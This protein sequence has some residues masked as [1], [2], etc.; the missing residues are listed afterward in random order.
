MRTY[1][2]YTKNFHG[3]IDEFGKFVGIDETDWMPYAFV[4]GAKALVETILNTKYRRLHAKEWC[5]DH[6]IY[7]SGEVL[8]S[9]LE[10]YLKEGHIYSVYS[11]IDDRGK[12]VDLVNVAKNFPIP[13]QNSN[14]YYK[15]RCD[16][17]PGINHYQWAFKHYYRKFPKPEPQDNESISE[18]KQYTRNYKIKN[19]NTPSSWDDIPR[20]DV[21]DRS[22]KR[23]RDR[24]FKRSKPSYKE[25]Y[26]LEEDVDENS[27]DIE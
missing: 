21:Y 4:K 10:L 22:W 18:A 15:F 12:P 16:A 25:I 24:Q 27:W 19:H 9:E 26:Q 1:T 13:K 17:V 5:K 20:S 6:Y 2:I 7:D 8:V 23:H 3:K 14:K 11:A